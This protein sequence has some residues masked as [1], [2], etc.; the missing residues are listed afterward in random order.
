MERFNYT[1]RFLRL[2]DNE[3]KEKRRR[4][5]M[6]SS[7]K[8]CGGYS[9]W[10]IKSLLLFLCLTLIICRVVLNLSYISIMY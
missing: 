7:A 6:P 8:D 2:H 9:W 4:L 10:S 3:E 5:R 1:E